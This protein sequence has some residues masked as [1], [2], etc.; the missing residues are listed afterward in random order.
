MPALRRIA[1]HPALAC[2]SCL[3]GL[4]LISL[5]LGG[6]PWLDRPLATYVWLFAV[7]ALMLIFLLVLGR[8]LTWRETQEPHALSGDEPERD[9]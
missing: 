2:L 7:W 5:P 8:A 9:V 6:E 1:S 3:L 4:V